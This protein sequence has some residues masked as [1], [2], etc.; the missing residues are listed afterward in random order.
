MLKYFNSIMKFSFVQTFLVAFTLTLSGCS[1]C[2]RHLADSDNIGDISMPPEDDISQV[3]PYGI[4]AKTPPYL[5]KIESFWYN[6]SRYRINLRVFQGCPQIERSKN[7][8]L[9]A[10][11]IASNEQA[12]RAYINDKNGN[13]IIPQADQPS[14]IGQFGIIA[15]SSDD[16]KTWKEVFAFD[17]REQLGA[18]SS[19]ILLWKDY[20]GKIRVVVVRN[21]CV[22]DK[23]LGNT[24]AWEFTMQDADSECPQFSK[25]RL[26]GRFNLSVI[27]PLIFKD[28]SILR[29]GDIFLE[30]NSPV[31]TKFVM[32]NPDGS[33]RFVSHVNCPNASFAEAALLERKD[34]SLFTIVRMKGDVH[35]AFESFDKAKTWNKIGKM[36]PEIGIDAKIILGRLASG[37]VLMVGNDVPKSGKEKLPWRS[38]MTAFLSDDDGKTFPH[39]LLLDERADVSYPSFTQA[40]DGYIYIAYDRGRGNKGQHEILMAKISE[41]DIIAGKTVSPNSRL[42][43]EISS[44]SKYGGGVRDGDKL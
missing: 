5:T 24:T 26:L 8:R 10:A 38:K 42:K 27:K 31:K 44:P 18:T 11:W 33:I 40:E 43:A 32:E 17:P 4:T 7:G 20:E 28:G 16:G 29:S 37:R 19:D 21:M 6:P 14:H 35:M 3:F 1:S 23:D 15:T 12:E 30:D 39:K 22:G 13:R 9:W 34:G 25:P 41:D 36:N 2:E